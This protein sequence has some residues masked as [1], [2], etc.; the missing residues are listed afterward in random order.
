[1]STVLVTGGSGFIA[2]WCVVQLLDAGHDVVTTVRST[3]KEP[4]VRAA[5]EAQSTGSV[6]QLRF[7]VADLMADD[8]WDEAM[9]GCD[10]VLHGR[11]QTAGHGAGV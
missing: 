7:A 3:E 8:G 11:G 1:M 2:G 9:A 5:V 10:Y 4:A 6:D